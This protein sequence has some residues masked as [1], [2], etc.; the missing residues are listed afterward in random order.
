MEHP[1]TKFRVF[2]TA[3]LLLLLI[4]INCDFVFGAAPT[5]PEIEERAKKCND[6]KEFLCI[7]D[8]QCCNRHTHKC[9]NAALACVKDS[10]F[11]NLD[12]SNSHKGAPTLQQIEERAKQCNDSAEFLCIYDYQCC[13]R[14][15]HKCSNVA[16]ACV[17]DNIAAPNN[18]RESTKGVR[19]ESSTTS[20]LNGDDES[21]HSTAPI[22]IIIV[23]LTSVVI[24]LSIIVAI[25]INNKC[26][27][28]HSSN[29]DQYEPKGGEGQKKTMKKGGYHSIGDKDKTK[30]I[31]QSEDQEYKRKLFVKVKDEDAPP[32]SIE[33]IQETPDLSK[34]F[35]VK[36]QNDQS[37]NGESSSNLQVEQLH[38]PATN[39]TAGGDHTASQ[40]DES[41]TDID[42]R[43]RSPRHSTF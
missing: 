15:T 10:A 26:K 2:S 6:S 43:G 28:N 31:G 32:S 20:V 30:D 7:Y 27:R 34:S 40:S 13:K 25:K 37:T 1:T 38:N 23:L 17:E 9:S 14:H 39:V 16:L 12:V 35:K 24:L 8:Y 5:L 19:H 33:V 22:Y 18:L 41:Y 11:N 29:P 36:F 3:S 21:S 4:S 42:K